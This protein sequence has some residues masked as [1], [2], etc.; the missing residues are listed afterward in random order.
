MRNKKARRKLSYGWLGAT[1]QHWKDRAG[2]GVAKAVLTYLRACEGAPSGKVWPSLDRIATAIEFHRLTVLK[3]LSRLIKRKLIGRARIA[4]PG[5]G[6]RN[7]YAIL[8]ST[9][10]ESNGAERYL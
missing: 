5:G 4:K 3:A 7:E 9:V 6:F 1:S 10:S 2:D 8:Q